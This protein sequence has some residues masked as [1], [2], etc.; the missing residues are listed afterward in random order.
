MKRMSVCPSQNFRVYFLLNNFKTQNKEL[1]F[2]DFKIISV[3]QG[4]EAA[5]WRK[6]LGCR[7]VPRNILIKE[8]P[9]YRM[10]DN[11]V[12]GYDGIIHSMQDLLRVF[13]LFKVGDLMFSDLLIEDIEGNKSSF[14][15]YL[16]AK[17]SCFKYDFRQDEIETFS[18]FGTKIANKI[19]Y[20]NQ[21]YGFALNH[22]MSGVDKGFLYRMDKL[23]K[24]VDYVVALES[25][26][27]I[28]NK[29]YFLGST[30]AKRISRLLK[31][32]IAKKTVKFMYDVRSR[33]I[34]GDYIEL[35]EN[36][37]LKEIEKM[38]AHMPRLERL[39]RKV[40]V[41]LF[42]YDFSSREQ[43]VE[44]MEELYTVPPHILEIMQSAKEKAD[45][46][47]KLL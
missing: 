11:D 19:G 43:I 23:E 16:S 29:P 7:V 44:F 26:F 24:I 47:L 37:G 25:L 1:D 30:L 21:F 34:H 15:P 14:N 33:I 40:F 18:K 32:H 12:S 20:K 9:N 6:K 42:D 5:E 8:F 3:K 10:R 45:K 13:R 22:F 41:K 2:R 4:P 31:D 27:L 17:P 28:D 46:A 35:P 36:R 38:K 39:M